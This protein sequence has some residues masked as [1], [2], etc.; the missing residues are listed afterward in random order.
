MK[1]G[2]PVRLELGP[3]ETGHGSVAG[4]NPLAVKIDNIPFDGSWNLHD[5]ALA[6]L[7]PSPGKDYDDFY[8]PLRLVERKYSM[9]SVVLYGAS[10]AN[11]QFRAFAQEI[12]EAGG[13]CEGWTT[14]RLDRFP[15]RLGMIGV[16]HTPAIKIQEIAK[17]HGCTVKST[18]VFAAVVVS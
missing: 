12:V 5:I 4:L 7:L 11:K 14:P 16:A 17:R 9:R 13:C 10:D 3:G 15:A 1:I 18:K 8:K 2:D 6:E